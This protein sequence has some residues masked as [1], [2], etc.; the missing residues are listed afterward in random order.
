MQQNA[1][2]LPITADSAS[3][4]F[5]HSEQRLVRICFVQN[6]F[7]PLHILQIFGHY[8]LR[9]GL[10]DMLPDTWVSLLDRVSSRL[11]EIRFF[12]KS[13]QINSALR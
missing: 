3:T 12:S 10:F 7:K 5:L 1:F 8:H 9:V 4:F 13:K 2:K 11:P 6:Y